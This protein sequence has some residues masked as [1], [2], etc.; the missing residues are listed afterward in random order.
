[1]AENQTPTGDGVKEPSQDKEPN[2]RPEDTGNSDKKHGDLTVALKQER[3][4]NKLL[5]AEIDNMKAEI[6]KG[7]ETKKTVEEQI[8]ELQNNLKTKDKIVAA[9]EFTKD[10]DL[11]AFLIHGTETEEDITRKYKSFS[12]NFLSKAEFNSQLMAKDAEIER[13]KKLL[14]RAGIV[15]KVDLSKVDIDKDDKSL[16][17]LTKKFNSLKWG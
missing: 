16:D 10:K 14:K 8:A 7:T 2:K 6:E 1:M 3:E 11:I 12:E 9:K 4:K 5:T 15:D 13:Y 17:T